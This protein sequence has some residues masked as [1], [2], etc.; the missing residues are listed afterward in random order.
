MTKREREREGGRER[1]RGRR[2]KTNI[3]SKVVHTARN[4][5]LNRAELFYLF[6]MSI[7]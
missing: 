5:F 1:R 6:Q 7:L 3:Q 4:C 2:K